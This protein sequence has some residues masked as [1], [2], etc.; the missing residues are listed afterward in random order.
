MQSI[1]VWEDM[2]GK[3]VY[4]DHPKDSGNWLDG[5]LVGS[6]H[7]VTGAALAHFRRVPR[8]EITAEVMRQ[9]TLGEAADIAMKDYFNG[10]GLNTLV[11]C[12]VTAAAADWGWMSGPATSVRA[13]QQLSGS[14]ADGVIGPQTRANYE[15]WIRRYGVRACMD[16]LHA[17]KEA[18]FRSLNRPEF[19]DGWL[20]RNNYYSASNAGF[21]SKWDNGL[22]GGSVLETI[23]KVLR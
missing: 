20:N 19:I 13:L 8:S 16:T 23:N 17:R 4:S 11:W 14:G 1:H 18:F 5:R 7:G 21:W 2:S 9:L 6:Q 15:N 3:K 22:T 10:P 12:P